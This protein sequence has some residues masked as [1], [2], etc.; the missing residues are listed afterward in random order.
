MKLATAR[1]AV[2]LLGA[3]ALACTWVKLSEEGK[4]VEA[5]SLW[6]SIVT[7]YG[8]NR[9]L[10]PLVK[11]AQ[12]RLADD[13]GEA[14]EET[15]AKAPERSA[16]GD[17][18]KTPAA[19]ASSRSRAQDQKTSPIEQTGARIEYLNQRGLVMIDNLDDLEGDASAALKYQRV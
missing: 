3:L 18:A 5:R 16:T 19:T 10:L 2:V 1:F 14:K 15:A 6:S 4:I 11:R 13:D 17:G 7:L 8:D 12:Q 9:E